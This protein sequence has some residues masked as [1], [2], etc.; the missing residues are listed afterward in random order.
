MGSK[1]LK[2]YCH[3]HQWVDVKDGALAGVF[4]DL[5]MKN[6]LAGGRSG[7]TLL[8]PTAAVRKE[9]ATKAYSAAPEEAIRLL[10]AHIIPT[11]VRTAANFRSGVGS[12]LGIKLEVESASDSD[13]T[14][15]LKGGATLK[16]ASDFLSLRNNLAVWEV[17]S[18]EVPLEGAAFEAPKRGRGEYRG[19]SA[20]INS[21][22]ELAAT[23]ENAYDMCMRSDRC[24]TKDPYLAHA[25]SLLNFLKGTHPNALVAV[26][27][28]I[29]RDPAVTFYLLVEP[30]KTEGTDYVLD[31]DVLFGPNGWNGAEVFE[32]AVSEFQGF[33]NSLGSQAA[34]SAEDSTSGNPVVPYVFRG[35]AGFI[36]S[37]IDNV[38]MQIIGSDGRNAN[39]VST[40]PLVHQ[41]Y[42][43]L[44]T[45]NA[46]SGAQP[47][48]PNDTIRRLPGSKKLWQDELR[49]ML[50]AALMG[51]R[52]Q[53]SYQTSQFAEIVRMLRFSRP[54]NHYSDE[55]QL[56]NAELLRRNV[57]AQGACPARA[58]SSISR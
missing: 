45:R 55:A 25:V 29:D 31:H 16:P 17:K 58:R 47:I 28:M 38:R 39:K 41:V 10:N 33:F 13:S 15:T 23:V 26:L 21:R 48:L 57:S 32:G 8:Y 12:R 46:I 5:C 50:H 40:P 1:K 52:D 49:F 19:G 6:A 35:D 11:A 18:G 36:R 3:I 9:I 27:P 20:F 54:G 14:V 7:A 43:I 53:P 30:Y 44:I 56:S 2:M 22:Q 24:R 37:G 34:P 4:T 51:L 42:E